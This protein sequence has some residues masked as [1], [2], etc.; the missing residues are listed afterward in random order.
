MEPALSAQAAGKH[1]G[2]SERILGPSEPGETPDLVVPREAP[3]Q[4]CDGGCSAEH[5]AASSGSVS[6]CLRIAPSSRMGGEERREEGRG[7]EE[8]R[9]AQQ[10]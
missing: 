2:W 1:T 10:E 6:Y 9:E 4:P 3:L 5:P 7:E 8:R